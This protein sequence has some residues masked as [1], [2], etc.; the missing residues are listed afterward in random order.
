MYIEI[1]MDSKYMSALQNGQE[2][3]SKTKFCGESNPAHINM[4]HEKKIYK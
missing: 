1:Y 3:K 2:D 4:R